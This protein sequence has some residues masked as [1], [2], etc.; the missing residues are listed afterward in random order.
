M[1]DHILIRY[2]EIGLK[3]KNQMS[4]VRKLVRDLKFKVKKEYGDSVEVDYEKG[5]IF[6][7]LNGEDAE[8]YYPVLKRVFG[9]VSFSPV[10]KSKRDMDSIRESISKELSGIKRMP[11]TFKVKTRRSDK[12]YPLKSPEISRELGAFVLKN[13]P[14]LKVDVHEP[15]MDINVE[16][17]ND[18][19]Y[20]YTKREEGLGGMPV[21]SA[22]KALLLLSGGIDSPVAGY[23]AARKGVDLAG[24]HFF[25]YPYTSQRAR[26]K[27]NRL[28]GK[29]ARY[30]GNF[31]VY[32]VPFTEI[33]EEIAKKCP[34]SYWI[35]IMRRFMFRIAEKVA[36]D[37]GAQTL[38]TGESLG[39]VAS[40]T[41]PSMVTIN[42]VVDIP[43][44]RPLITMDK[45][46]IVR[47]GKEIG[48][49]EI[50]IEPYEDC[51]TAFLPEQPKTSP[52]VFL[53]EEYEEALDIQALV[54]RAVENIEIVKLAGDGQEDLGIF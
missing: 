21:N 46:E 28:A 19:A 50:S 11:E 24:L 44:L 35:T 30:K 37:I 34:E 33:Q 40:Q 52:K 7:V 53:A 17:R 20:V 41:L 23:L 14:D 16:I 43:V 48:T 45:G 5:R 36:A 49:Y 3:G 12:S 4:F 9:I 51:C 22:G 32:M 54:D 18:F 31:H 42:Q 13:F 38:V 25:S 47:I 15:Q 6:M 29:L 26:D 10:I 1:Y 2:G 39:Q 27:V 8:K